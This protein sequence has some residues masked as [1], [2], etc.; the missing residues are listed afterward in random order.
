[1]QNGV[2]KMKSLRFL[3]Q[4]TRPLFILLAVLLY[5]LGISIAHYLSGPINWNAFSFGLAWIV[6]ILLGSQCLSEYFDPLA[7][8][9]DP[10]AKHTP[11]SGGSGAVGNKRLPRQ[12][13]L[14]VGMACYT[15]AAAV[16]FLIFQELGMNSAVVLI[17]GLFLAGEIINTLPPF[18]LVSTGYG[19]VIMSILW[20]GLI[21]ALAYLMQGHDFHRILIMVAFPLTTLHIGM[22]L[23]ME[24]PDYASDITEGKQ[25][26]IVRI[27]WQ[28]AMLLHNI[29]ILG[30][31]VIL[32]LAFVF[33]LPLHV[34]W[35]V[36][37]VL[38]V[39]LYQIWM[40]NR[41]ADG[42]RP[43]WSLLELVAISTFGLAAY[44]LTFAFWTH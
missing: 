23:A 42:A 28:R 14:W 5:F 33:G 43:N 38:P 29:L 22:L 26:A 39:G 31:F 6:F 3:I 27:G 2:C 21:P 15:L 19:E 4:L 36:I 44:I 37:F 11:F 30:S 24:F 9:D 7:L 10:P 35:P 32:A 25:P 41:I 1:M 40:M 34:A 17:L 12:A 20:V 16:T 8:L 18:R 13:V